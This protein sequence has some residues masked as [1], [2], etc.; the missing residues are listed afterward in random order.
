MKEAFIYV[1]FFVLLICG[2]ATIKYIPDRS[3]IDAS[4]KFIFTIA[5]KA[6]RSEWDIFFKNGTYDATMRVSDLSLIAEY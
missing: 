5:H 1:G 6:V 3:L 2:C 4:G